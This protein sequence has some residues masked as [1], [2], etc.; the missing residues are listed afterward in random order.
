VGAVIGGLAGIWLTAVAFPTALQLAGAAAISVV[1]SVLVIGDLRQPF[2]VA[3]EP[4]GGQ[5]A[6]SAW[7]D[8]RVLR[9]AVIVLVLTL[10][11]G[12]A[13]DWLP[14]VMVD[15]HGLTETTSS[16]VYTV[17]AASMAVGRLTGPFVLARVPRVAVVAGSAGFAALGLL[18]AMFAPT[19]GL[20]FVAACLW[21]LGASLAFPVS[22]SASAEGDPATA[23]G[24]VSVI[25]TAGYVGF[26]VGPPLLGLLGE[27]YGLRQALLLVLLLV[28]VAVVLAPAVRPLV[29]VP[30]HT[31]LEKERA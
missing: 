24:R 2:G 30:A 31:P 27:Q 17:F 4:A 1:V 20:A 10:A 25:A 16:V 7:R 15:G 29:P 3:Q 9:I 21:G 12:T 19:V 8:G 23:P 13:N 26:L 5:A 28:L 11:E 6:R 14:L 18:G 22:I